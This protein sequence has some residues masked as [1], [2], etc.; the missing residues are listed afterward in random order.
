M[1][2]DKEFIQFIE[3]SAKRKVRNIVGYEF[4]TVGEEDAYVRGKKDGKA[5]MAQYVLPHLKYFIE[6]MNG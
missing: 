4:R 6:K 1:V 2:E 5:L 3:D